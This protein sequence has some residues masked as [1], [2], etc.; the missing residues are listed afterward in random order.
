MDLNCRRGA[1]AEASA[2]M[3]SGRLASDGVPCGRARLG[4]KRNQ[5]SCATVTA[6]AVLFLSGAFS[7]SGL[8]RTGVA[9][10]PPKTVWRLPVSGR[11]TPVSDGA[12]VYFITQ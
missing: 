4:G 2:A 12:A 8:P 1:T 6:A 7:H 10:G 5:P 11:G 9:H 3:R